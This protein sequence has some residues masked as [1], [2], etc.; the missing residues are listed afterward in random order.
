MDRNANPTP[1]T[2]TVPTP[3]PETGEKTSEQG[4][5][6]TLHSGK[7]QG[8]TAKGSHSESVHESTEHTE[9]QNRAFK[10]RVRDAIIELQTEG[11]LVI[12]VG[13]DHK[14]HITGSVTHTIGSTLL[15]RVG[16]S[17]TSMVGG[18]TTSVVGGGAASVV[19][20]G[21]A[22]IVGGLSTNIN[23]LARVQASPAR[24]TISG[25]EYKRSQM[26][27]TNYKVKFENGVR[28]DQIIAT[29][30]NKAAPRVQQISENET[31]MTTCRTAF[32]TLV[33]ELARQ[34]TFLGFTRLENLKNLNSI[35]EIASFM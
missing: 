16:G 18:G 25:Y 26:M 19:G 12:K 4:H 10:Q 24:I 27:S 33:M 35:Q 29:T 20:G 32:R 23:C 31:D 30:D 6:E 22:S 14:T 21:A 9:S 28:R 17:A 7:A 34:K 15:T 5:P 2:D 3:A 11:D 13:G 8:K 1:K